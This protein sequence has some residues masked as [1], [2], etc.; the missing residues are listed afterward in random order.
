MIVRVG[1]EAVRCVG[2][3]AFFNIVIPHRPSTRSEHFRNETWEIESADLSSV[4]K[5]ALTPSGSEILSHE[6]HLAGHKSLNIDPQYP[7]RSVRGGY[8]QHKTSSII[9]IPLCLWTPSQLGD[10]L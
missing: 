8:C 5:R 1:E 2:Q 9:L 3:S 10:G 4:V 6:F 7:H